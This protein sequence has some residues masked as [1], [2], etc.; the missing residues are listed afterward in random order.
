[1]ALGQGQAPVAS[2]NLEQ[3]CARGYWVVLQNCH[4]MLSWLKH[5]E[6]ILDS[7][8]VPHADF[9]LFL[10]TDPTDRFPIGILQV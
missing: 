6:K 7:V 9:R 2:Q 10:T 3:G 1:M 8:K 4:L 5:L